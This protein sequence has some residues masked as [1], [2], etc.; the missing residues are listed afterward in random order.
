[1]IHEGSVCGCAL[2]LGLEMK[3]EN[4]TRRPPQA[5]NPVRLTDPKRKKALPGE[6]HPAQ[7][8]APEGGA[9][10]AHGENRRQPPPWG[11]RR[12]LP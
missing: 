8:R 6:W 5:H 4:P 10:T 3:E 2:L 11:D 1:M 9:D 7:L 12:I